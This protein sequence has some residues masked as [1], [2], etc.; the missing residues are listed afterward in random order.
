M[1]RLSFAKYTV[2]SVITFCIWPAILN[3]INA[4]FPRTK[5][6]VGGNISIDMGFN[7]ITSHDVVS[8]AQMESS[9]V[10]LLIN[11]LMS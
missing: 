4:Y 10:G 1:A 8:G 9:P 3:G 5:L 7:W 2:C 6:V 11:K